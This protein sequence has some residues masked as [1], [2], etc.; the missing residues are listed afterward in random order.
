MT[1]EELLPKLR[2]WRQEVRESYKTHVRWTQ[3]AIER[4]REQG[5]TLSKDYVQ[6]QRALEA[7]ERFEILDILI[8]RLEDEE[9]EE[10]E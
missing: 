3:E 2:K 6:Y 4:A 8:E 10:E 9:D 7:K 5:R 1:N